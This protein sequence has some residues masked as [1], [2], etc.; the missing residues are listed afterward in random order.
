[1]AELREIASGLRF[2]EGPVALPGGD[3]LVCE[4]A[5]GRITRISPDGARTV[6][7]ETG[8]GPNGAALGPDGRLWVCNN[9]GMEWYDRDGK[10]FPIGCAH[11]YEGGSIQRVDLE[12]GEVQTVWRDCGGELLKGPNDL[13]FDRTGGLWFTD[14]GKE[15]GRVRDVTGLFYAPADGNAVREVVWPLHGPNGVGLS[16][17]E[18]RVYVAETEAA[19]LIAFDLEAPGVIAGSGGKRVRGHRGRCLHGAPGLQFFDSLAVEADGRICVATIHN[20]GITVIP[21]DGGAAEHVAMPDPVTTNIAFGG[22]GLGS[23][24]ITLSMSG[25]LVSVPW[26]RPGLPLNFLNR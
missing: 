21:P 8:G 16:P 10:L 15:R 25:R 5:A 11:D 19:R 26:A 6:A 7:A 18:D 2:P 13:V 24:F 23:A 12:T 22:P 20:G 9:G 14:H 17:E 4:I 3:V 1:M